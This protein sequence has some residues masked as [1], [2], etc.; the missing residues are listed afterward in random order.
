MAVNHHEQPTQ[1]PL[2]DQEGRSTVRDGDTQH[3]FN[4]DSD[5]LRTDRYADNLADERAKNNA[6]NAEVLARAM[7]RARH[8]APAESGP[9]TTAL[10]SRESELDQDRRD[11]TP[12]AS[13]ADVAK[14]NGMSRKENKKFRNA[15]RLAMGIS[16]K[17]RN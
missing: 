2:F 16:E 4:F 12:V 17:P 9:Q 1:E 13:A 8:S 6:R 14:L 3:P 11:R 5:E 15:A 7:Q 10:D